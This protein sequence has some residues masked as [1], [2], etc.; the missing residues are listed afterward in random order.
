MS[1]LRAPPAHQSYSSSPTRI[2][3]GQRLS[4]RWFIYFPKAGAS[5]NT[6]G[7]LRPPR[8]ILELLD[9]N[10]TSLAQARVGRL[11]MPRARAPNLDSSI[12]WQATVTSPKSPRTLF[13]RLGALQFL[14]RRSTSERLLSGCE[15][16]RAATVRAN[17]NRTRSI[18]LNVEHRNRR[19]SVQIEYAPGFASIDC[20]KDPDVSTRQQR[21]S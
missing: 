2:N 7:Q 5:S 1:M 9:H 4:L 3:Q 13:W 21:S 18:L 12:H 14:A 17:E 19:H 20:A 11:V 10:P 15:S 6:S 8:P 16:I